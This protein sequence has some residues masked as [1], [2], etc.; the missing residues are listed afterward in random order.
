MQ[1]NDKKNAQASPEPRIVPPPEWPVGITLSNRETIKVSI[2]DDVCVVLTR[3]AFEQLL[4]WAYATSQ[5]ISCLGAVRR[6][7]T[8]FVV[9]QFYLL[10]Q[11]G[12][13][14]NTEL[15]QDAVAEFMEQLMAEGRSDEAKRIK[16]WAHSHPTMGVFWSTTDDAT[17]RLV[18]NDY[19][20][21]LVV[22][23]N[24]AV[25]CRIDVASPFQITFDHIPVFFQV[26]KHELAMEKYAEEVK[27]LVAD[28]PLGLPEAGV[29]HP[30]ERDDYI[31]VFYCEY[32]GNF[33]A[34]GECPVEDLDM[35]PGMDD[36]SGFLF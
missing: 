6:N 14:G 16:C 11:S 18:V 19:L 24:F 34:E 22:S 7:D 10:R 23:S 17:C 31:P 5:E 28:R 32:C 26:P 12:S 21:S 20:I 13:F 27:K 9:E 4:G 25:Q 29:K 3:T 30:G 15:H 36:G 2:P 35:I 1:T 33:H 8:R